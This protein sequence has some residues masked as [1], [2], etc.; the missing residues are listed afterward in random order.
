MA[1]LRPNSNRYRWLPLGL[2]W[3]S[4]GKHDGLEIT[5]FGMIIFDMITLRDEAFGDI[6]ITLNGE[7]SLILKFVLQEVDSM[8][9]NA[10]LKCFRTNSNGWIFWTP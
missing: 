9:V 2:K 7:I 5:N 1:V 10:G 4:E 8:A 6:I 3:L